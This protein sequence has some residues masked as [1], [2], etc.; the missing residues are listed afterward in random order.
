M[1]GI[2]GFLICISKPHTLDQ[3]F[4]FLLSYLPPPLPFFFPFS[5]LLLPSP[6]YVDRGGERRRERVCTNSR[7][8]VL[9]LVRLLSF[10]RLVPTPWTLWTVACQAPLSMGFSRQEY[11]SGLPCPPP[12]DLPDPGIE[13]RSLTSPPLAG[14]FFTTAATWEAY[15]WY[16]MWF[17]SFDSTITPGDSYATDKETEAERV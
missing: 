8:E 10:L 6:L 13:P 11:W 17:N 5:I 12:G 15:S 3:A 9:F 7:W 1:G 4:C 14:G 2:V 16:S